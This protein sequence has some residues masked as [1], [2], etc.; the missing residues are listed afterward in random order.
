M[1]QVT[2]TVEYVTRDTLLGCLTAS[3]NYACCLEAV[4]ALLAANSVFRVF[5]V[6]A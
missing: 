6:C 3:E 5:S 1:I 2:G 4:V